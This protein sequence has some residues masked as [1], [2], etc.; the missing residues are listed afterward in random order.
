MSTNLF[1]DTI[2]QAV[3]TRAK[4]GPYRQH[5]DEFKHAAV[6][7]TQVDGVSVP[8]VA[9]DLKI[10][11][12]WVGGARATDDRGAAMYPLIGTATLNGVD[13]EIN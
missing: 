5:S 2:I 8:L 10:N 4:R 13:L 6:T 1:V 12:S 9:R 11:T 3:T 7:R